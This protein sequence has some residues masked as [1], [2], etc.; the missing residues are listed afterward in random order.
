MKGKLEFPLED[1]SPDT[2]YV[3]CK[4]IRDSLV[5]TSHLYIYVL[6]K[7]LLLLNYFFFFW[8]DA[9]DKKIIRP[10]SNEGEPRSSGKRWT[11]Y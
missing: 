4:R 7:N 6:E 11:R 9:A 2:C 1:I 10:F 3:T 8:R 5:D